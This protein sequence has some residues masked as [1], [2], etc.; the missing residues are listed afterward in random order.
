[1]PH[2]LSFDSE[3]HSVPGKH[4][5]ITVETLTPKLCPEEYAQ[6]RRSVEAALFSVFSK[7]G[8][9]PAPD[10]GPGAAAV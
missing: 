4:A 7:Y 9:P 3:R 10:S 6:R 5:A 8:T 1:M 2:P